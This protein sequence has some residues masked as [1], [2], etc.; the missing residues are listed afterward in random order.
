MHAM[1][2]IG[3][4]LK[5]RVLSGLGLLLACLALQAQALTLELRQAQAVVTVSGQTTQQAVSLPY[6]WDRHHKGLSG[7][8]TFELPF[9]LQTVPAVPFGLY[10]P[11]LG[12]AYEIWL[13]DALLQRNGDLQHGNGPDFAKAPRYVVISPGLLRLTNV[14]RVHIRADVG[15][16]AGL[17]TM[18]LGPEDE[19]YPLYRTENLA[20]STAS[21][22]VIILSLF[23]GLTA[24]ALWATQVDTNATGRPQRDPLYLIAGLAELFWAFS[25]SDYITETPLFPWPWWGMTAIFSTTAWACCMALFCVEVARWS[26]LP[27]VVWLRRWLVLL[28]TA[29][30]VATYSALAYG[31]STALSVWYMA[32][33]LSFLVF[34]VF[35]AAMAARHTSLPRKVV[36]GALLLNT[37]M[38]LHDLYVL[39][40][41]PQYDAN[42]YIR[43]SS[44][45]FGLTLAYIVIVRFRAASGQA[46]DLMAGL[47]ERVARREQELEQSYQRLELLAREQERIGERTRIL[48]DMHDGVGSHIS[49]AI[50]QMESGRASQ[51][52]VLHTLR[53]SLDQLKLSIDAIN[54]PSG[55]L[56]ALLA[57]L[58]Y[59][60][61]PRL[62]ASD[63][64]LQWDVDLLLPLSKLDDKAMRHLQFMV[65]EALSNVM[66]HARASVVRIELHT[67]T[68]G[69]AQLLIV[70]NGCGFESERVKRSGLGSLRE[71][72]TAIGA[73]LVINSTPG[74]TVV[75]IRLA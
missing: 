52:D 69:G 34:V 42:T 62:K 7:E 40:F 11:R 17:T 3:F 38:G 13:N 64:E 73:G 9:E 31:Y 50:R 6:H 56:T 24:L 18:I 72:A 12:N 8:A 2:R 71:R 51:S 33:G 23:V 70:D 5:R 57:N 48:R 60:L 68:Q 26:A 46:R 53:D 45:L 41:S 43:Y 20:R 65:F 54:L 49:T 37:L 36:G 21:F 55:D 75:E 44:V 4:C 58:R 66:Q 25:V 16:R 63:I 1:L 59:R 27:A 29:C 28:L 32:F 35:Y 39:R 67:T 22:V 30:V 74:N 15:R 14:L 47:A 19:V 10:L 61:E